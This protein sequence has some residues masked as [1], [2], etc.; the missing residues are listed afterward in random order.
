MF[1]REF[2]IRGCKK[3]PEL[4]RK[5]FSHTYRSQKREWSRGNGVLYYRL[6][7]SLCVYHP[8]ISQPLSDIGQSALIRLREVSRINYKFSRP[9]ELQRE[10]NASRIPVVRDYKVCA[11]SSKLGRGAK[12]PRGKCDFAGKSFN[13]MG[14]CWLKQFVTCSLLIVVT[15]YIAVAILL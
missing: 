1:P 14:S 8:G 15:F 2:E 6:L 11:P 10:S 5:T 9:C 12:K 4:F 13:E 7:V 3:R